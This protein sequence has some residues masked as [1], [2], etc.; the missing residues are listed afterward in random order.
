PCVR[1]LENFDRQCEP[2]TA[3]RCV[4]RFD[5]DLPPVPLDNLLADREADSVARIFVASMQAPEDDKDVLPALGRDA[6]AV[7]RNRE[8]PGVVLLFSLDLNYGRP[9]P[10]KLDGVG[11]QVLKY[12]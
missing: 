8:H 11:D 5:P 4:L 12:L 10:V 6:D 3:S 2:E 1:R 9:R 7:V